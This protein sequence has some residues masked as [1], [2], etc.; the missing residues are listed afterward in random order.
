[1]EIDEPCG[2]GACRI[3]PEGG[4]Y[5]SGGAFPDPG[6][7]GVV[8][9]GARL[10]G[11]VRSGEGCSFWFNCVVRGDLQPVVLGREC[12]I[13][14][15]AVL[16]VTRK[17]GVVLG[18]RVTIGHQAVLHGCTVGNGVLVGMHA[19]VLD[20][21][22]LEDGCMVA[23]G[24]LV[25]PG[26]VV[27]ARTLVAGVPARKVRDLKAEEAEANLQRAR[28]YRSAAEAWAGEWISRER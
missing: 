16:H 8:F 12:N 27:E 20:G 22:V 5:G 10:A 18:D 7:G 11:D 25:P 6:P 1:M 14:D 17:L 2:R 23:A 24:A 4:L 26:M 13:Q 21:A 19:T 9:P 28:D 3:H 15:G